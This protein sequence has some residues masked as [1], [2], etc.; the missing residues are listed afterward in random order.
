MKL[1]YHHIRWLVAVAALLVLPAMAQVR[2][3]I[4]FDISDRTFEAITVDGETFNLY[5]YPDCDHIDQTG[6]P[7]LPVKYIRLSVPYNATDI[8]V[9]ASGDWTS[10]SATRRIYPA[11]VPIPTDGSVTE[12]PEMVIDS[13]IYMTNA[14]WPAQPA[15]LVGDGILMGENHIVT[16]AVYPMLYNPGA[17]RIRNY[18]QVQVTVSYN[19][20][21]TPANMLVRRGGNLRLQE[22][23]SVKTLVANPEKVEQFAMSAAQIQYMPAIGLLPDSLTM[24]DSIN[25]GYGGELESVWGDRARYLIVTTR[26]LAPAFKRLAALKRQKGYSV[27]IKCIED[28]LADPRV[29][30]G[31]VFRDRKG[32][33]ISAINDDAGKLRQYLKIAHAYDNTQF[34]LL[35]GK[36]SIG[37]PFRYLAGSSIK[38][39]IPSDTYYTNLSTQWYLYHDSVAQCSSLENPYLPELY[40][41]RLPVT[42]PIEISNYTDKLFRY[43]LNPG[44]GATNYLKSALYTQVDWMQ[45][46]HYANTVA[47]ELSVFF[48][49]SIIVSAVNEHTPTG[50][51]V[52]NLMN[53]HDFGYLC[54]HAHGSPIG[55]EVNHFPLHNQ[56]WTSSNPP[57]GIKVFNDYIGFIPESFNAIEFLNNKYNPYVVYAMSCTTMPFD[58]PNGRCYSYNVGEAFTLFKDKGAVAY[59]GYT[60]DGHKGTSFDI[61]EAFHKYLYFQSRKIGYAVAHSLTDCSKKSNHDLRTQNLFGDPEL[62]VWTDIPSQIQS[63]DLIRENN[64]IIINNLPQNDS[65]FIAVFHNNGAPALYMSC[66]QCSISNVNPNSTVM[67]YRQNYL[68]YIAP[69]FLQNER[70]TA[71]QYVIANDVYAG[72]MVDN[73]RAPGELTITSGVEYEIDA[74]GSVTLAPGFKVEKGALF[75]VTRS[76]Y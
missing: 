38:D 10:G 65:L 43:E 6:A 74:R 41:G 7:M 31:D 21:E 18:S 36:P 50:S 39:A 19:L 47:E 26:S 45:D 33:I 17:S 3:T 67:V 4:D 61:E 46:E 44:N 60:R 37:L 63:V 57:F 1:R 24:Q 59:V 42:E 30:Q 53:V 15:E 71:S 48:P 16:V 70:I 9:T 5:S 8:T 52:I 73:N 69:L 54:F 23:Q 25:A 29:Q 12:D 51:D 76:D 13:A 68:P 56:S 35:A 34:V 40:V 27:Q 64:R 55:M 75:S 14:F 32:N 28:I 2:D 11:P 49:D 22:Q 58:R 66:G 72:N 62:N 20:G